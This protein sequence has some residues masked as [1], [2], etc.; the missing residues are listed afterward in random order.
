LPYVPGL[1][2]YAMID[3]KSN[4]VPMERYAF[5]PGI[6][7]HRFGNGAIWQLPFSGRIRVTTR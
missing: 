5:A 7:M 4:E 2:N 1:L 3:Q 6:R